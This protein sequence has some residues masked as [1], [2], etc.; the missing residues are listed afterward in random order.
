MKSKE[1][2]LVAFLDILRFKSY[3]NDFVESGD[4]SIIEKIDSALNKAKFNVNNHM[5]LINEADIDL[6]INIKQFSDC[7]SISF[8]HP[9]IRFY[10]E[11]KDKFD[12]E[13]AITLLILR[14]FQLILLESEIYIRGGLSFGV[15]F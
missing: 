3:I 11:N 12:I 4:I 7:T 14:D 1:N 8:K 15:H 10:E 9:S 2:Y 5:R 13:L 6:E